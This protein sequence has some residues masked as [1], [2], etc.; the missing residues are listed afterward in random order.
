[1]TGKPTSRNKPLKDLSGPALP[2]VSAAKFFVETPPGDK[3]VVEI[4]AQN[5]GT[6]F[7]GPYLNWFLPDI[8]LHCDSPICL[9]GVQ[10]YRAQSAH[11][12]RLEEANLYVQFECKNCG[13]SPKT[14]SIWMLAPQ[15]FGNVI[16]CMKYGEFPGFGPPPSPQ[17]NKLVETERDHFLKGRRCEMQ[18]L[19]IGAFTY[20]R[21]M[22]EGVK[23]RLIEKMIRACEKIQPSAVEVIEELKQARK[24]REFTRAMQMVKHGLPDSLLMN[25]QNPLL[26]LHNALSVGVHGLDD[27]ACLEMF[28]Q[29][30][31]RRSPR[32]WFR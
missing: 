24:E 15:P 11:R 21:R 4:H 7:L 20:Y 23:D 31:A 5:G 29:C 30:F 14:Y 19:G 9:G 26:L 12:F 16:Q 25:E 32:S 17:L 2:E 1:M 10:Q 6:D 8:P 18:G 3:V 13:Q 28:P 22:V 27:K